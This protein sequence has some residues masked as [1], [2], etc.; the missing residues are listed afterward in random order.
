[1]VAIQVAKSP[2]PAQ[3]VV[4]AQV[5]PGFHQALAQRCGKG[6]RAVVIEQATHAYATQSHLLQR[7]YHSLGTCTRLDQI[8]FEV[9][10][11]LGA[12]DRLEHARKELGAVDQ[13]FELIATPPWEDR[14]RHVSGR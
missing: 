8:Q 1:M 9:D 2:L 11:E 14:P 4:A 12:H 6:Q 3:A 5:H 10:L 7:L 13:Q